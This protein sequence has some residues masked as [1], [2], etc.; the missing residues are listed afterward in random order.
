MPFE[1]YLERDRC[2]VDE[3]SCVIGDAIAA[4][5]LEVLRANKE[6]RAIYSTGGDIS[7]AINR[8][9]GTVGL[10]LLD[11]V[12]PLAGYG[13]L[14]GGEFSGMRFISKGGMVGDEK[15]MITCA[16]YLREKI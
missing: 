11:E 8:Q 12:V 2:T 14:I 10:R 4:V 13:E 6:F 9:M 5:V 3:L 15:A 1:P 7:A 16:R